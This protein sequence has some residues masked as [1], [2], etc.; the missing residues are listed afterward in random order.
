MLLAGTMSA[1]AGSTCSK[2][3][4]KTTNLLA[5]SK[6][7]EEMRNSAT[8]T[9]S[10][11]SIGVHKFEVTNSFGKTASFGKNEAMGD[12]SLENV[13]QGLEAWTHSGTRC[14]RG[15]I[16]STPRKSL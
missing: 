9:G 8:S 2:K 14:T 13:G 16:R 15:C 1:D 7:T 5:A 6:L 12:D 4:A 10:L 11:K 3:L